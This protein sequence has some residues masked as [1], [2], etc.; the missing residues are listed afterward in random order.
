MSQLSVRFVSDG[1]A[2]GPPT[3]QTVSIHVGAL[4]LEQESG[5][6]SGLGAGAVPPA[7][8]TPPPLP[9]PGAGDDLSGLSSISEDAT[10]TNQ[11]EVEEGTGDL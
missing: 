9:P 11:T 1:D 10:T 2:A 7:K 4:R 8:A 5:S 3:R 6:G